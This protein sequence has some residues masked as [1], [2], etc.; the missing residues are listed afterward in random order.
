MACAELGAPDPR[1]SRRKRESRRTSAVKLA[2]K[3]QQNGQISQKGQQIIKVGKKV[4]K[5]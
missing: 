2:Q 1:N 3:G 4:K 5:L